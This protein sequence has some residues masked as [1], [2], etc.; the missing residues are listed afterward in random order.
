MDSRQWLWLVS[1]FVLL[2]SENAKTSPAT[3][4]NSQTP[5]LRKKH[6]YYRLIQELRLDAERFRQYFYMSHRSISV[7]YLGGGALVRGPPPF[8]RTAVIFV[9]ILGLFL[10]PFRHKIAAT[11]VTRCVFLA[12]KCSKMRL[13]PG[14]RPGPRWGSLQRPPALPTCL[15]LTHVALW[16]RVRGVI[17]RTRYINVLTL[18]T[19]LLTSVV[20]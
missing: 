15:L 5:A 17:A 9:T 2:A 11:T 10:A 16:E 7:A 12:G 1:N 18:M 4:L 14:L 3:A 8:G 6:T 19:Y 13:R 20:L